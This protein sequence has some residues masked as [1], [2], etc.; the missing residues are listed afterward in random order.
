M[1]NL[2]NDEIVQ[3]NGGHMPT[4]L[5]GAAIGAWVGNWAYNNSQIGIILNHIELPLAGIYNNFF[6][7]VGGLIGAGIASL[8]TASFQA[9]PRG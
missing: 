4:V 6:M 7:A 9:H 8:F 3:V 5:A 2:S 1:R